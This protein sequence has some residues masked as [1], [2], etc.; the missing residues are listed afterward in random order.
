M[1]YALFL[2]L[3]LDLALRLTLLFYTNHEVI[4]ESKA[5]VVSMVKFDFE[6]SCFSLSKLPGSLDTPCYTDDP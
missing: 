1:D 2:R 6:T 3:Q 5:G 4:S